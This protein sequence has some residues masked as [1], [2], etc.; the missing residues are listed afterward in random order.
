MNGPRDQFLRMV[1]ILPCGF[2]LTAADTNDSGRREDAGRQHG[3]QY[4]GCAEQTD[5]PLI[6]YGFHIHHLTVSDENKP[7]I[8]PGPASP[9]TNRS[10]QII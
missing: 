1:G 4:R 8:V 2:C 10:F 6:L 3:D 9:V 7:I 5:D